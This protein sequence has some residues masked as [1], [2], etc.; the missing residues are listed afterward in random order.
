[1]DV[2]AT[3]LQGGDTE[4]VPELAQLKEL[5]YQSIG[6]GTCLA[7]VRPATPVKR[8]LVGKKTKRKTTHYLR[9]RIFDELDQAK[10]KIREQ[11]AGKNLS[12][13]TKSGIV[14]LALSLVLREF[15]EKGGKSLLVRRLLCENSGKRF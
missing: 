13:V 3:L 10:K 6:P 2:L 7:E 11:N 12:R 1:M 5:L 8:K 4:V 15:K 14:N 9:T